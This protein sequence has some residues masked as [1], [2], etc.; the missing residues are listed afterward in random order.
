MATAPRRVR[1]GWV[2]RSARYIQLDIFDV[3]TLIKCGNGGT[4]TGL[5]S[6]TVRFAR[7]VADG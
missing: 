6:L 4:G 3:L 1:T 2:C 7:T 5:P